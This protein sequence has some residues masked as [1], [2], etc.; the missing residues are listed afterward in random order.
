MDIKQ[1]AGRVLMV[2]LKGAGI[3]P[4]SRRKLAD[5]SPGG[6]ILFDRNMENPEQIVALVEELSTLLPAPHLL[7]LDQEGGR[8]SRLKRWIGETPAA[9]ELA[10]RD[11]SP[12]FGYGKATAFL[13]RSL[14][15]NLDF[16]PVVDLCL[17]DATNGIGD[18]SFGIEP[19]AAVNLAGSFLDGLQKS[20][21]AG[22]L[23]HFPGLGDTAVDSHQDLPVCTRPSQALSEIDML[24]FR[25]LGPR[26][27]SVMVGHAC[28]PD[29]DPEPGMPA[30]LSSRIVGHH[31]R[32]LL[33]YDGL[34]VSDDL[35]MGAV[36]PI[37][38][39]GSAALLAVSAGCDLVLYCSD[40]DRALNA[41]DALADAAEDD[42]RFAQ[43]LIQAAQ[44]VMKTA[45]RWPARR[46]GLEA[47]ESARAEFQVVL[48]PPKR[49][50]WE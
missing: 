23:K 7:A 22:C 4:A 19:L 11:D 3:D 42:G 32:R 14:G 6:M 38:R 16:A 36:S 20:G 2:G 28:Y 44:R 17:P 46:P 41:R 8:V 35:E 47:W 49:S 9:A 21:V 26:A 24:P 50:S 37:D 43:R 34:V 48:S 12:I 45:A 18:R 33:Q 40:L 1:A 5:L 25:R 31:L 30:S 15:F 10:E 13:L 27:A 29:L 39:E